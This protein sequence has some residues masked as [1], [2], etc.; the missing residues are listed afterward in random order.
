M[1]GR[2]HRG[3]LQAGGAEQVPGLHLPVEGGER[4]GVH[5][6]LLQRD[7][8]RVQQD[9]MPTQPALQIQGHKCYI[10][11][12]SFNHRTFN[13]SLSETKSLVLT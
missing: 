3:V 8:H 12:K 1:Q 11:C 10:E 5:R 4:A 9:I 6:V 2:L 7:T 13:A